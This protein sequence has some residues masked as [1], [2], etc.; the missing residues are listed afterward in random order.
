MNDLEGEEAL[1]LAII[2]GLVALSVG[3]R[4]GYW[5]GKRDLLNAYISAQRI[6][7]QE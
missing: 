6:W 4:A 3:F 2:I 5:T 1:G 7:Q